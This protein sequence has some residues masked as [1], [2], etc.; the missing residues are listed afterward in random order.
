MTKK[1]IYRGIEVSKQNKRKKLGTRSKNKRV[2]RDSCLIFSLNVSAFNL[3]NLGGY[4]DCSHSIRPPIPPLI[5]Y[6]ITIA[7]YESITTPWR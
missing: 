3:L 1:V 5:Y 2:Y 4:F 6:S 7:A